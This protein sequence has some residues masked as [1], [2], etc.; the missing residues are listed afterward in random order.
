MLVAG[1][2]PRG[3]TQPRTTAQ[4]VSWHADAVL[5]QSAECVRQEVPALDGPET[6][7]MWSED[8]DLR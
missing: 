2:G 8:P 7:L 1:P 6:S 3:A 5:G 4:E